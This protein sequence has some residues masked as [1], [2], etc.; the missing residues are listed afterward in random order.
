MTE[1]DGACRA[2]V[3]PAEVLGRMSARVVEGEVALGDAGDRFDA[4][5]R[6]NDPNLEEELENGVRALMVQALSAAGDAVAA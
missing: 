4:V 2:E 6:L 3:V 5:G 1:C